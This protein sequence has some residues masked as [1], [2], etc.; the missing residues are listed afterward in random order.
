LGQK[1]I[2]E[3]LRAYLASPAFTHPNLNDVSRMSSGVTSTL[4]EANKLLPV[5]QLR[6]DLVAR[7]KS[8]RY[9]YPE[10]RRSTRTFYSRANK[11]GILESLLDGQLFWEIRLWLLLERD[12]VLENECRVKGVSPHGYPIKFHRE[13]L[14]Q[15]LRH[16]EH[17]HGL[18][19]K[20]HVDRPWVIEY[21]RS[22]DLQLV[23]E[24]RSIFDYYPHADIAKKFAAAPSDSQLEICSALL[25]A[26]QGAKLGK[27]RQAFAIQ[28]TSLI[29]SPP[30]C[31]QSHV[32]DPS[33]EAIRKKI[34]YRRHRTPL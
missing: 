30:S 7:L 32:L 19:D 21:Q 6:Q 23:R 31:I 4:I 33:P 14:K 24:L 27:G 11:A 16:L 9:P 22:A 5:E 2:T 8:F 25:R 3:R 15:L 26:L 29:C 18:V 10:G 17:V 1:P 12:A 13:M 20:Y 28:F 34:E